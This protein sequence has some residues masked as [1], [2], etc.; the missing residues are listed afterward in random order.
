MIAG[1]RAKAL[2]IAAKL[3]AT[4]MS[5]TDAAAFVGISEADIDTAE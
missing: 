1:E 3:I 2:E 5:K 4:G